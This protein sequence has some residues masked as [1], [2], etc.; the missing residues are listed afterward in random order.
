VIFSDDKEF[1]EK[2]IPSIASFL[3]ERLRLEL[4]PDKVF[5]KTIA[6]GIDFLGWAPFPNHRVLRTTTKRRMFSRLK[7][8]QSPAASQSYSGLLSHGNTE[9]L[10]QKISEYG[11]LISI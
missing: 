8:T 10:R 11:K 1:L 7:R 5:I 2:L 3:R 4:H 9:K 6:S